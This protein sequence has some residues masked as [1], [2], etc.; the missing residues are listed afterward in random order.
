MKVQLT[1]VQWGHVLLASILVVILTIFLNYVVFLLVLMLW[2]PTKQLPV[3]FLNGALSSSILMILLTFVFAIWVA[4]TVKGQPQ[5]H[6]FLVGLIVSL[7]LFLVTSGFRGEFVWLALIG[8]VLTI[9]AGW[10]GGFLV[11]RSREK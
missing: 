8:I 2:G 4:L 9:E 10:L 7:L 11:R 5:L 1:K 3:V 6:G